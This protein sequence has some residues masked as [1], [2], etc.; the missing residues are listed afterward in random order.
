MV[1]LSDIALYL[2]L[3]SNVFLIAYKLCKLSEEIKEVMV[4]KDKLPTFETDRLLLKEVTSE[5]AS[6]YKENF[7]DYE[8]IKHLSA[9][10]PWPYPENGVVEFIENVIVPNQGKDRWMWGI[11]LRDNPNELIG[12]IDLWRDGIP[13]HRGFWLGQK[14]WG[15]GYMTEANIPIINYAFECLSFD[16]LIFS[17]A[18]GNVGSRKIKE[19]T[20][21]TFSHFQEGHFVDPSY[22]EREIWNLSK[23]SW[24]AFN[25]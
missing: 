7:V 9:G 22:K 11:F 21:A 1:F 3:L 20:G 12:G 14:Y 13:E 17:N 25:K 2:F 15:N 16:E 19:K 18:L 10:V 5:H 23:I 4:M 8:V 6:S 24:L